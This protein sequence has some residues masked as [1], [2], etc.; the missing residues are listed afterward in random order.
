LHQVDLLTGEVVDPANRTQ[1]V[2]VHQVGDD[3]RSVPQAL[4]LVADVRLQGAGFQIARLAQHGFDPRFIVRTR[5]AM[6]PGSVLP[7]CSAVTVALIRRSRCA[8]ARGSA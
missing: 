8:P 5:S 3:R 2:P 7:S 4:D 6:W 1:L